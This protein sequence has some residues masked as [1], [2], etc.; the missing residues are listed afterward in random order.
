MGGGQALSL[1]LLGGL[2]FH[3]PRELKCLVRTLG[4]GQ[5]QSQAP[6]L[7]LG[8]EQPAWPVAQLLV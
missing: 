4:T 6:G 5:S 2:L 8:T 7:S 1:A 3:P